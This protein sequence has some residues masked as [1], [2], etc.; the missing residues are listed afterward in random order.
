MNFCINQPHTHF[1]GHCCIHLIQVKGQLDNNCRP[2]QSKKQKKWL[3]SQA[4]QNDLPKKISV[5][6]NP[7]KLFIGINTY[8][9]FKG[10]PTKNHNKV[11]KNDNLK[12]LIINISLSRFS[13]SMRCYYYL[14]WCWAPSKPAFTIGCNTFTCGVN[15]NK[16]KSYLIG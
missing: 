16:L 9:K 7:I 13:I 4:L 11:I 1:N 3:F 15:Y 14:C 10:T 8:P 6:I 2:C 12:H 5:K